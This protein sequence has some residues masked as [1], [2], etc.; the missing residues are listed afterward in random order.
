MGI[1]CRQGFATRPF[2]LSKES[3]IVKSMFAESQEAYPHVR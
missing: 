1:A 2:C 3:L